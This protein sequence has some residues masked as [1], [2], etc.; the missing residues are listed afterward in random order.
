ME[1]EQDALQ[2]NADTLTQIWAEYVY[3][4]KMDPRVNPYV[5]ESWRKCKAAGIDPAEGGIGI[6]IDKVVFQN[7]LEE[8]QALI[9]TA[10]PIMQS[11]FDVMKQS[12]CS[13]TLTDSVGYILES[14]YDEEGM[15]SNQKCNFERGCLWSDLS[16]GTNALG[17]ALEYNTVIQLIG[18]QHYC[19]S[20]HGGICTAAPIHNPDGK[21][22]G[23]LNLS[24]HS[25]ISHPHSLG[26]ILAAVQGIEGKLALRQTAEL[27]T[28]SLEYDNDIILLLAD[29]FYPIWSNSTAQKFFQATQEELSG[30]DFRNIIPDINLENLYQHTSIHFSSND[31]RIIYHGE[32]WH[33]SSSIHAL[34]YP[35]RP[36]LKVTIRPQ[37]HLISSVNKL[38][39]NLA[40]YT[41]SNI[42]TQDSGMKRVM[43]LAR[44]YAH[45]SGNILIEG[46]SGTGKELLAQAIHNASSRANGPFVVVNCASIPQDSL[47]YDLFGYESNYSPSVHAEGR[48]GHFELANHGTLFLDEITEIPF[49]LQNKLLRAV[50]SHSIVRAGSREEI[51]L[52]IRIIASTNHNLESDVANQTF[53]SA[54]FFRL[55]VLRLSIPPLRSR[56]QDAVYCANHFLEKFNGRHPDTPHSFSPEFLDGLLRYRWP[57]N[58]RELQNGIERALTSSME[59]VLTEENLRTVYSSPTCGASPAAPSRSSDEAGR[60]RSALAICDGDIDRAAERLEISRATLYRR[61]KKYGIKPHRVKK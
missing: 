49:E 28:A 48:P 34:M 7:I 3:E 27:M 51:K 50:E 37:Q 29:N 1:Y 5:A 54:L 17:I 10:L 20:H 26:L 53:S 13:L 2:L 16:V 25:T 39:G 46:E 12:R 47:I 61:L 35:E 23:A 33:C 55:N 21:V 14:I 41:F 45:Y 31:T 36:V 9:Q 11:V 44:T 60:I 6:H 57:G 30:L 8:N 4:D 24:G 32:T 52:D 59:Q 22:I 42:L 19:R 38:S 40:N 18:A 58:I 15:I 43:D 56:M